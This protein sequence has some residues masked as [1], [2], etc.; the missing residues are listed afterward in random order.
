M[1]TY[2]KSIVAFLY[3]VAIVGVPLF[4][5]DHH[6]DPSEAVAI[7]IAAC[8]AAL[9]FL[10][11][12][13]PSAPWTKTAIGAV[14]AGLQIATTVIVGGIDGNDM[15]LIAAAILGALGITFAPA[16]SPAASTAVGWGSDSPAHLAR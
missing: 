16:Y 11:P 4:T 8:T 2:G 3:A 5:G 10:V 12:L 7:A 13:V 14:L 1:Q 6:I 9:T 15:L